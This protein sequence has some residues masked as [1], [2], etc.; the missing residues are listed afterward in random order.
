MRAPSEHPLVPTSTSIPEGIPCFSPRLR[1]EMGRHKGSL[2]CS[3]FQ[4]SKEN[5]HAEIFSIPKEVLGL[6]LGME[7]GF[8]CWHLP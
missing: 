3:A 7:L 1:A 8:I 6:V 2:T 4:G 5:H